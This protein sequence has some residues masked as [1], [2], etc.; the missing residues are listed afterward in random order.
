MAALDFF[1]MMHQYKLCSRLPA[2]LKNHECEYYSLE[3]RGVKEQPDIG[4][5]TLRSQRLKKVAVALECQVAD[6][7]SGFSRIPIPAGANGITSQ[8]VK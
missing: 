2:F 3:Q 5:K 6:L 8:K 7:L 4:M 1:K